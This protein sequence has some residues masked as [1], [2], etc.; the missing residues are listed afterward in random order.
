MDEN[1]QTYLLKMIDEEIGAS[2]NNFDNQEFEAIIDILEGI[3]SEKDYDWM[4]NHVLN[5][6]VAI[7]L[8]DASGWANQMFQTRDFVQPRLEGDKPEDEQKCEAVKILLN[9]TLN[10][11]DLHFYLKYIRARMLNWLTG[12]VWIVCWWEQE[13]EEPKPEEINPFAGVEQERAIGER[14]IRVDRFNCTVLDPRNV[15]TDNS[16][17]YSAQDKKYVIVRSDSLTYSD[18]E[19]DKK[20]CGYF[21]LKE[22]K[23]VMQGKTTGETEAS[24][25]TYNKDSKTSSPPKS[26]PV[27]TVDIYERYGKVWAIVEER[28]DGEITKISSGI[29]KEG[30]IKAGAELV[31]AIV[32]KARANGKDILIRFQATPYYDV[33]GNPYRPVVRGLCYPHPI[34]DMGLGDGKYLRDPQK[35]VN[36]IFNMG[37]DRQ[38]LAL[39]PTLKGKKYSLVDNDTIRFE[40]GHVMELENPQDIEEIK[41]TDNMQGVTASISL[42]TSFMDKLPSVYPTTMGDLPGRASTTAT[43]VAGAETR[44]NLRAN[45]KN[46]TSE[47]T[48]ETELYWMINQMSYRFMQPQTAYKML[49]DL[50]Y[51]YDADSEYTYDLITANIETEYN[52]QRMLQI[53]DQ[54]MGRVINIPNPNTPK[55]V[56]YLLRKAF[57]LFGDRFP[58]YKKYLLDDSQQSAK[59]LM[60]G[61][62]G[63]KTPEDL[64]TPTTNQ[65]GQAMTALEQGTREKATGEMF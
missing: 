33:K 64:E 61:K 15:F 65:A 35:A 41:I 60:A 42:L 17:A 30:E 57:D 24:L 43:A 46:L 2:K 36:D 31:E 52:K 38:R 4:S 55:L 14:K 37:I 51:V 8:T 25:E 49:G 63:A 39:M 22:V 54:F 20:R 29:D 13:I 19:K 53:I 47:Y 28:K 26:T 10:R 11:R 5:E 12:M 40:P 34:K 56:N 59:M 27:R 62:G 21:N 16:Y 48:F 44:T 50:V 23:E 18:L 3:R 45:F 32:T 58:Q 6:Y 1:I 7:L 9:K